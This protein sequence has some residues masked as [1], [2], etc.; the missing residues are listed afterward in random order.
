[1]TTAVAVLETIA[2]ATSDEQPAPHSTRLGSTANTRTKLPHRA[3]T[4]KIVALENV[5]N[6]AVLA[7]ALQNAVVASEAKLTSVATARISLAAR[8]VSK[9]GQ[10]AV[11]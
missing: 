3:M 4:V 5:Q 10:N 7:N 11:A 8:A 6:A 1:M 2:S 9:N